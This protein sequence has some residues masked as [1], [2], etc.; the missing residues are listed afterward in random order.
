GELGKKTKHGAQ[1]TKITEEE[2][3]RQAA[4]DIAKNIDTVKKIR[5]CHIENEDE[6]WVT[7]YDDIGP[8]IDLKQYVW[9]RDSETLRPFL[10]LKRISHTRYEAQLT[11][12]E[13]D[14]K[15]E[16]LDPPSKP[17]RKKGADSK[18]SKAL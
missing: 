8:V 4:L 16:V 14:R 13:P 17:T 11:A 2:A 3:I 1:R 12:K 6:W 5:I 9:D 15:C 10:V 7:L 18:N